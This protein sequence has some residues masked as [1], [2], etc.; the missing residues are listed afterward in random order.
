M[1][2]LWY[3]T[4]VCK[5]TF[6]CCLIGCSCTSGQFKMGGIPS[7][8]SLPCISEVSTTFSFETAPDIQ[9]YPTDNSPSQSSHPKLPTVNHNKTTVKAAVTKCWQASTPWHQNQHHQAH[10]S[11]LKGKLTQCSLSAHC[12]IAILLTFHNRR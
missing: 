4:A 5:Y 9:L 11:S 6:C 7:D 2:K 12:H 1:N 8:M 3:D 10:I